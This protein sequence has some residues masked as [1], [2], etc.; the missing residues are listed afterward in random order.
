[1]EQQL[2]L[3]KVQKAK[4]L[5]SARPQNNMSIEFGVVS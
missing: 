4:I 1:M 5:L 3:N 2:F